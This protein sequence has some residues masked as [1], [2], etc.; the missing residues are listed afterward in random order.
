MA[1][2]FTEI[3]FQRAK[4]EIQRYLKSE[5]AKADILFTNASPYGQILGVIENLHQVKLQ[6][7]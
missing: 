6:F 5:Y 4:N 2:K 3:T 1:S 7:P